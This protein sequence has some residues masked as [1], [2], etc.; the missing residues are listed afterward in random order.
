MAGVALM[1]VFCLTYQAMWLPR[2]AEEKSEVIKVKDLP[3]L[4]AWLKSSVPW[5]IILLVLISVGFAIATVLA[6]A[7]RPPNW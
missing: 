2:G 7:S 5:V 1:L 4:F 6:K 3:S